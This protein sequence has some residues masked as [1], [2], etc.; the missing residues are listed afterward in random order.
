M[1]LALNLLGMQYVLN[2]IEYGYDKKTNIFGNAV[3]KIIHGR[4]K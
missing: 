2:H 4:T 3:A 1:A